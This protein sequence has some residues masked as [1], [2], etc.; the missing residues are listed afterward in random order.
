[1]SKIKE[2][3]KEKGFTLIEFLFFLAIISV[4]IILG[5]QLKKHESDQNKGRMIG[6]KLMEY[7]QGV[8]RYLS[9]NSTLV[10]IRSEDT[11]G[12]DEIVRTGVDW[13]RSSECSDSGLADRHYLPCNFTDGVPGINNLTFTTRLDIST[14]N[15]M[16][17][18][19]YIDFRNETF[20]VGNLSSISESMLGLAALTAMGGDS[21]QIFTLASDDDVGS[22]I[23]ADGT[24]STKIFLGASDNRYLYC[25]LNLDA[26]LLDPNCITTQDETDIEGGL[27]VA[28]SN[29]ESSRDSWVRTDGSNFV[30]N[31]FTFNGTVENRDVVF[32]NRLYNLTGE[33]L[34]LGN[35]EV[36]DSDSPDFNPV[37]GDGVVFD[38]DVYIKGSISNDLNI[39][40]KGDL[41]S[42]GDV[43]SEQSIIS[44]SGI[45]TD[46]DID[47]AGDLNVSQNGMFGSG[48][49]SKR[50]T[51]TNSLS[52]NSY[53]EAQNY[54]VLG[55]V[56]AGRAA[57]SQYTR[58][59][60]MLISDQDLSVTNDATHTGSVSIDN[61]M[62]NSKDMYVEGNLAAETGSTYL[63]Q[64]YTDMIIDNDGNYILD[65]SN[66][67]LLDTLRNNTMAA[68]V[69][70]ESLNLNADSIY[71][72]SEDITC[73]VNDLNY[74][75]CATKV[76]GHVDLSAL[77]I[78]SPADGTWVS[79]LDVL[80]GLDEYNSDKIG[81]IFDAGKIFT[82][83]IPDEL[84]GSSCDG[85]TVTEPMKYSDAMDAENIGWSC[86][87]QENY[88]DPITKES[89]YLCTASCR[90]PTEP[91]GT[92]LAE[93]VLDQTVEVY[94]NVD[95]VPS[96]WSC[97]LDSSV[98]GI[99]IYTCEI[100]CT[101]PPPVK[102]VKA[103]C[104]VDTRRYDNPTYNSCASSKERGIGQPAAIVFSVG[105]TKIHDNYTFE[106]FS[107]VS[108]SWSGDCTGNSSNCRING[109]CRRGYCP[110][111]GFKEATATVTINGKTNSYTVNASD[112]TFSGD[113]NIIE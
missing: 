44:V 81:E 18:H 11:D 39:N 70:G 84:V 41:Y 58:A 106:D 104:Y 54:Y 60:E 48:A 74:S 7:N 30:D 113:I 28:I 78:K 76:G 57:S 12:N 46:G 99:N 56:V 29:S 45:G 3:P 20:G 72:A 23:E 85:N 77:M 63:S 95:N 22:G 15:S 64:M 50:E 88:I 9:L 66:V 109:E 10:D 49:I 65:P 107:G 87:R 93:G 52:V 97:S 101:P 36:F 1:M 53:I 112:Y 13:L 62:Y 47:S 103:G 8:S 19:T 33:F 32:V 24:P 38:T 4:P 108:I 75:E 110:N 98:G 83:E 40:T 31:R 5:M 51:N 26:S 111:L 21:N 37:L 73:N 96:D 94:G 67:S 90:V 43:S 14:A 80:N 59:S 35:S 6:M 105:D 25:P 68:S 71:F 82:Q 86:S 27:L 102:E 16:S 55:S 100:E 89:M 17:S 61:N 2:T 79:F 34:V 69:N 42:S 92:C 91:T